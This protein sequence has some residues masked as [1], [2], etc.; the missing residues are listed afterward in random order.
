[1]GE[2]GCCFTKD[3]LCPLRR[4]KTKEAK[5][6]GKN[7]KTGKGAPLRDLRRFIQVSCLH[8]S[9]SIIQHNFVSVNFSFS[10]CSFRVGRVGAR[11]NSLSRGKHCQE[12]SDDR[13]I[14][15]PFAFYRN[16]INHW[17]KKIRTFPLLIF[18]VGQI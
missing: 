16:V 8:F 13:K 14:T 11:M 9:F 5:K 7:R 6:S 15:L 2:R 1:M 12:G 10:M 17:R 3:R 18:S 4:R